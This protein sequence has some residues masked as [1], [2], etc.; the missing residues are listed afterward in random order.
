MTRRTTGG[1]PSARRVPLRVLL[2]VLGFAIVVVAMW[3]VT[4]G[5]LSAP[6]HEVLDVLAVRAHLSRVKLDPIVATTVMDIR[7]PRIAMG[8]LVGASLG[9]CG[10]AMQGVFRNPL[11]DPGLIGVSAGAGLGA[12]A[13]IVLG[14]DVFGRT[15]IPIAAFAGALLISSVVY[16][17]SRAHGRT[18]VVAL[19]L[20][21][22]AVNAVVTAGI[23]YLIFRANDAQLRSVTFWQLGSLATTKWSDVRLVLPF[24]TVGIIAIPQFAKSLDA[25]ALGEREARHVGVD[26]DAVRRRLLGLCAM[27]TGAAVALVGI[28]AFVGLVVPHLVRLVAG[29]AHRSVLWGS[30]FGGALLVSSA[31]LAARKL[32]APQELPLGV[33]TALVGGVFFLYL[34]RRT[35]LRADAT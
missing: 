2:P 28:V 1:P 20:T 10:A 25:M 22:I 15:T 27:V 3:S 19:L 31:D 34:L 26:P 21:G 18:N 17:L 11:A 32:V 14:I 8:L 9:L 24:A 16:Q 6:L 5:A 4:T 35:V 12:V 7:L 29:P 23:A 13:S 33:I 30:V